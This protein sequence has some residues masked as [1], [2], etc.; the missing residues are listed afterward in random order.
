MIS[1][2]QIPL[3]IHPEF[4]KGLQDVVYPPHFF[5]CFGST[6]PITPQKKD[7]V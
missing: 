5:S 1:D 6:A 7:C 2:A 3:E 4:C